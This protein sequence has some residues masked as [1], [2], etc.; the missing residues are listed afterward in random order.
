[1]AGLPIRTFSKKMDLTLFGKPA[2]FSYDVPIYPKRIDFAWAQEVGWN[3]ESDFT[4]A[5]P[6]EIAVSSMM[7][8]PSYMGTDALKVKQLSMVSGVYQ[9]DGGTQFSIGDKGDN[10]YTLTY[11]TANTSIFGLKAFIEVWK[12]TTP[13]K[14]GNREKCITSPTSALV[15][16]EEEV[17]STEAEEESYIGGGEINF[18]H[19]LIS[20]WQGFANKGMQEYKIIKKALKEFTQKKLAKSIMGALT[21][22]NLNGALQKMIS[23]LTGVDTDMLSKCFHLKKL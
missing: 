10:R 21:M 12:C 18:A 6:D 2:T 14:D 3:T 20:G 5:L 16:T 1:M 4:L 17:G 13:V 22:T 15:Q 7:K 8:I 19:R 9:R 11:F 23:S